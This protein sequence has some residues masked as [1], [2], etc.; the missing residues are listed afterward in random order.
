M[1]TLS[2]TDFC[3]TTFSEEFLREA[4]VEYLLAEI[5]GR[6]AQVKEASGLSYRE[7][8]RRMGVSPAIVRRIVAQARPHKVPLETFVRFG[9]A[10]GYKVDLK[11]TSAE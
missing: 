6:A 3:R 11:F 5:A 9:Q 10:C 4:A 1:T 7:I 8:A 2:L